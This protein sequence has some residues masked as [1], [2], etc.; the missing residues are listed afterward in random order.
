MTDPE[1]L[2]VLERELD[3]VVDRLTSMPLARAQQAAADCRR[4]ALVIVEE[5][6]V[7]TR[8]IPDDAT[9]PDLG[10][11]GQGAMLAVLG[12]DYV[13]A[14]RRSPDADVSIVTD[15]LVE[16]RRALP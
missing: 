15:A 7:L 5:T 16:L 11:Q 1:A 13:A 12:A 9:V 10:P 3:R 8:E 2:R 6:R 14:A 4:A